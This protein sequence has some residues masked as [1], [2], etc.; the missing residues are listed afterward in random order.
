MV[1]EDLEWD[2]E[3]VP[4]LKLGLHAFQI[5]FAFVVFCLEIA[6]FK[7]KD[8]VVTGNNGWTFAV[9]SKLAP[10]KNHAASRRIH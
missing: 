6:V 8:S 5:I 7:A 10:S 3:Y 2:A 9:V 4:G 1:F